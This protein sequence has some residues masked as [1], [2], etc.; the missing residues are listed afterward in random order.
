MN[1][2]LKYLIFLLFP[3]LCQAQLAVKNTTFKHGELLVYDVYYNW[4]LLWVSAGKANFS[5]S[6]QDYK[7][8]P[9][10]KF[11]VSGVSSKTFDTFYSVRDTF[12]SIAHQNTLLPLYYKRVTRENTYWAQD[13][14]HFTETGSQT[15]LITDCRKRDIKRNID[16][17]SFNSTVTDLITLLYRLRNLNFDSMKMNQ[18]YPFS[19]LF[20]DDN[21]PYHLSFEY[22]G[23]ENITLH[24]GK[25]YRCIKIKPM[26][27]K[28]KVFKNEKGM[29]IWISDDDN[30][31]PLLIETPVRVGTIKAVLSSTQN[32]SYPL[33]SE[34]KE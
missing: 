15:T 23:K 6:E 2:S 14:Y 21:E 29:T 8:L 27:I 31:L 4:G 25:Q 26:V 7:G 10:Y 18:K 11:F 24:K 3:V 16:T 19:I 13:E 20:D 9:S 30:K 28:G 33:L 22:A 34:I 5:V 12:M 32:C 17:L 1:T